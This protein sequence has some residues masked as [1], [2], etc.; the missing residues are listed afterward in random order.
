MVRRTQDSRAPWA[1]SPGCGMGIELRRG[2]K[3]SWRHPR[4]RSCSARLYLVSRLED[5]REGAQIPLKW[6]SGGDDGGGG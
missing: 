3:P 1:Q 2:L 4:A 5:R 6:K